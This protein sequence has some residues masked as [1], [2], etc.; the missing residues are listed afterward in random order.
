[1]SPQDPVQRKCQPQ[2]SCYIP[3]SWQMSPQMSIRIHLL[4]KSKTREPRKEPWIWNLI[5]DST[6]PDLHKTAIRPYDIACVPLYPILIS[7]TLHTEYVV[8]MNR[9]RH[10]R[11]CAC[12]CRLTGQSTDLGQA[13]LATQTLRTYSGVE[14]G[15]IERERNFIPRLRAR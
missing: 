14:Y 10:R 5:T 12:V 9:F 11:Q 3:I 8:Q 15:D 2:Y 7:E 6:N 13:T 1:M 4:P